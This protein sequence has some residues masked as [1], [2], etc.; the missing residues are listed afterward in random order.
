MVVLVAEQVWHQRVASCVGLGHIAVLA[1]HRDAGDAVG[2]DHGET[3]VDGARGKGL[4]CHVRDAAAHTARHHFGPSRLV[5][6]AVC[7]ECLSE[8]VE[9]AEIAVTLRLM[10]SLHAIPKA[11]CVGRTA[12]NRYSSGRVT[13]L[14]APANRYVR[15]LA[16]V[17]G[18]AQIGADSAFAIQGL[19]D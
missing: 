1:H 12:R 11:V 18:D 7:T 13:G 5:Q 16:E 17:E 9:P 19:S 2:R 4:P 10:A 15:S 3:V 8:I 14:A 6:R